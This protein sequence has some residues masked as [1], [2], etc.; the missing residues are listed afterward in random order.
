MRDLRFEIREPKS[1]ALRAMN[2][3][4]SG[5]KDP[6]LQQVISTRVRSRRGLE[7]F[8]PEPSLLFR[9]SRIAN[10]FPLLHA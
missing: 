1:S 2:R 5:R 10:R 8:H 7:P 6:I 3:T 9:R 4:L